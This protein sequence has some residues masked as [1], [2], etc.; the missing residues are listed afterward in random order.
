[1][2]FLHPPIEPFNESYIAVSDLHTVHF[3]Q[4]GN[5][6]G[7]PVLFVHG[8]PGS[9]IDPVYRRFFNP[10]HYHAILVNQR[11]AGKS[12]PYCETRENTTQNL[13]ADFEM[14]RKKLNISQWIVFG[15]SWGSTLGLAYAQTHPEAVLHLVL[16]GI[17]LGSDI[18]NQWLFGGQGAHRIFPEYWHDFESHIP[19]AERGDMIAAYHRRLTDPDPTVHEPAAKAWSRWEVSISKLIHDPEA[20][21]RYVNSP[22]GISMARFECHYMFNMCFLEPNQLLNN[23]NRVR[24]IPGNIIHGR[25]DVVCSVYNAWLLHQAWPEAEL[26]IVDTAGHSMTG[27]PLAQQLVASMDQLIPRYQVPT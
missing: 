15:G 19:E 24:H 5:P 22:A 11:G 9:G 14:I 17:Y 25:Y 20:V 16:R 8:G 18:E 27:I 23:I 13:I 4:C 7:V 6:N 2:D 26:T 21:E 3:E 10:Q 12:T 1:M